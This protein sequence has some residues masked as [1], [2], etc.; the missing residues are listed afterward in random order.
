[1]RG[2]GIPDSVIQDQPSTP[3]YNENSTVGDD[4]FRVAWRDALEDTAFVEYVRSKLPLSLDGTPNFDRKANFSQLPS[5][6]LPFLYDAV[7]ALGISM[8]RAGAR[9]TWFTGDDIYHQ[10]QNLDFEGASGRNQI[11]NVTGTRLY[12]TITFVVWNVR[13][14]N[15][16]SNG[17]SLIEY[18]PTH[19]FEGG[20]WKEI[21]GNAFEYADGTNIPPGSLPPVPFEYNYIG[22]VLRSVSYSFMSL[23][24]IASVAS[25]VWTIVN[26]K[27]HVVDSAQPLFLIMTAIGVFIMA[28]SIIPLSLDEAIV[29]QRRSLD[30]ACMLTPWF[31]FIGTS[32]AFGGLLAKA[33]AVHKVCAEWQRNMLCVSLLTYLC[34]VL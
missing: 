5:G 10:F 22:S 15:V 33:K 21:P 23:V 31:Y 28:S 20:T 12:E 17:N 4:R 13:I 27:N 29:S 14:T 32:I 19:S 34:L 30:A 8:C 9:T 2:S 6:F 7:T 11:L 3:K 26:R 25:L 1:M 16:V 18:V 24:M